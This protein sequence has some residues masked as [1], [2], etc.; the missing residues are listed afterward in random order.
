[1]KVLIGKTI[2]TR[3]ELPDASIIYHDAESVYNFMMVHLVHKDA[4]EYTYQNV[5]YRFIMHEA[6]PVQINGPHMDGLHLFK[7]IPAWII[8]Q[9]GQPTTQTQKE[10]IIC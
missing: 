9:F 4:L 7:S 5:L 3:I 2:G 1:M 10:K 8:D 6:W